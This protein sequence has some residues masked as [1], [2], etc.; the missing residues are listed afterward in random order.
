MNFT[1]GGFDV[2]ESIGER[3]KLVLYFYIH[4]FKV[5]NGNSVF[6]PR[7]TCD[8]KLISADS[9]TP[10]SC[11]EIGHFGT[12]EILEPIYI[13]ET[14]APCV[15][16][17]IPLTS[18]KLEKMLEV[19]RQKRLVGF[20]I[21]VRGYFYM[22]DRFGDQPIK[23]I[24]FVRDFIN[25]ESLIRGMTEFI[26]LSSEEFTEIIRKAKHYELLTFD[27]AYFKTDRVPDVHIGRALKLLKS[28]SDNLSKGDSIDALKDVRD[29]VM[30]HLLVKEKTDGRVRNVLRQDIVDGVLKAIPQQARD[31]YKKVLKG[32]EKSL[33]SLL[34]NM[35]SRFIHIDSDKIE[36]APLHDDVEFA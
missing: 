27:V 14:R 33:N 9:L 18:P 29:A 3:P 35:I 21:E 26:I 34:Q 7:L 8:I 4:V 31:E 15:T 19:R 12:Y 36:Q 16:C 17:E 1:F 2:K 13:K 28:A 6:V 24:A 32:V 20:R 22:G 25:N 10:S 11:N 5:E 23:G 30:N